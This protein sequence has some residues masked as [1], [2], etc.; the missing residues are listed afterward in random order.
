MRIAAVPPRAWRQLRADVG[1]RLLEVASPLEACRA[2][3]ADAVCQAALRTLANPYA[4]EDEPGAFHTTGWHGAFTSQ[5]SPVAVAAETAEDIA[6]AVG[7]AREHELRL[8][9]KGTGHDYLGRS[10]APDSL[11]VWTH[12]MRRIS[13]DDSFRRAGS[14]DGGTPAMTVGAGTRWLEAYQAAAAQGRYVQGGGCTSVGAAGGFTQGSGF[15]SYTKRYGTAAGN[16]LEM[17]VVTADGQVLVTNEFRHPDLFWALRGG[18]GGTFGVV[19]EMTLRTHPMPETSGAVSGVIRASSDAA[20]L[21]LIRE[22]VSLYPALNTPSWGELISFHEDN[23]VSFSMLALELTDASMRSVWAPL[24]DWVDRHPGT[25]SNEVVVAGGIPFGHSWDADWW[26]EV[27]P[28]L[29]HRDDR[30]RAAPGHYWWSFNQ[31]E[32]S[33]YINTY[34]S[35]WLPLHLFTDSPDE[36]A[37]AFF[38]ASRGGWFTIQVNKGLSGLSPEAHRRDAQTAVNPAAFDAAALLIMVS[39]QQRRYPGIESLAPDADAAT[40]GARRVTDGLRAI[41]DLTP[42]AGSYLNETDY[43]DPDW[44]QNS[45]GRNYDRLLEV[46]RRYDPA[47]LFRVHHGVGSED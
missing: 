31:G 37:Q 26:D 8:V 33:W 6:A 38:E 36:L 4:I 25:Y 46:K 28:G 22:V 29:I 2:D 41:R 35:R 19:A 39:C 1:G 3:P 14:A 16:V 20:Y 30:P 9:V 21:A 23:S 10:S 32:V 40:R 42:G 43:F 5:P 24:L 18:G 11:L 15:G 44:R 7:F 17:K 12:P 27:S 34:Q 45:W 13:L 47:N